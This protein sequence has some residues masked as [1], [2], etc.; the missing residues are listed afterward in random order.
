MAIPCHPVA[1][2]HPYSRYK[3]IGPPE[4]SNAQNKRGGDQLQKNTISIRGA[5]QVPDLW[6]ETLARMS[7]RLRNDTFGVQT[8]EG[9]IEY[10]TIGQ[11]NLYRVTVSRHRATPTGPVAD[12]RAVIKIIVQLDGHSIYEQG[13]ESVVVSPGDCLIYDPA[14]PYTK[15]TPARSTH[16]AVVFPKGALPP[17]EVR[18]PGLPAQRFS[19][20]HG[21]GRIARDTLASTFE[22]MPAIPK[23]YE[24]QLEGTI[25]NLL[26]L[27]LRQ[28]IAPGGSD[29]QAR[30][31]KRQIKAFIQEHLQDP[32]L[33]V[34]RIA[35]TL[36][37]SKRYL[38]M[39]FSDEGTTIMDSIW[40]ERLDR[41][42]MELSQPS[43]RERTVTEIA[44]GWGFNS[45]SHFSH[46]FRRKFSVTPS[47]LLRVT[48]SSP[49]LGA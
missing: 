31:I 36:G 41:C 47:V 34:D 15:T 1:I 46:A 5:S 8:F 9:N 44:F 17:Q 23:V 49:L 21:L 43:S 45:S 18:L 39:L 20:R 16:L 24:A 4:G 48:R 14:E 29:P 13:G 19:L 38:H 42:L 35:S 40:A 32:D 28:N 26:C 11:L 30:A 7:D 27:A 3:E 6:A 37:C 12:R 22:T 10:G 2:G 25:L 33:G